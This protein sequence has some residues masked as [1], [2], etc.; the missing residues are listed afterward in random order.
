MG[1]D[2]LRLPVP[3]KLQAL[4]EV[5][6]VL[7]RILDDGDVQLFVETPGGRGDRVQVTDYGIGELL[8]ST[9]AIDGLECDLGGPWSFWP[10]TTSWVLWDF[11]FLTA[12]TYINGL[13]V[14]RLHQVVVTIGASVCT[15]DQAG[16]S[17]F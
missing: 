7:V 13:P 9:F 8:R 4:G 5:R 1:F 6:R 3:E 12:L 14:V 2:T 16:C 11:F 15:D 10:D 17:R